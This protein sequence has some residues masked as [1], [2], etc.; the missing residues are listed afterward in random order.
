MFQ[1][2][3]CNPNLIGKLS[4]YTLLMVDSIDKPKLSCAW[5]TIPGSHKDEIP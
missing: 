5:K 2:Q 4:F 1:F 3:L